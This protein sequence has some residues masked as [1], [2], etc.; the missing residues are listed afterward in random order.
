MRRKNTQRLAEVLDEVLKN[1]QLQGK[2]NETAAIRLWPEVVGKALAEHT[3][4]LYFKHSVLH[5]HVKSAIIRNELMLI[6]PLLL[7]RLN[8]KIGSQAVKNIVLH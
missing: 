8:E 2:L 4:N 5:V 6:R 3:D 7:K 1:Q